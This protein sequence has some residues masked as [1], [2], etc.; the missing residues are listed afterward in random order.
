VAVDRQVGEQEVVILRDE[1]R[2]C[3]VGDYE[4]DV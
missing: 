2:R 1:G 4:R 3:I